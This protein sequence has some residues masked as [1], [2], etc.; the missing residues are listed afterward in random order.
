MS[1]L[2]AFAPHHPQALALLTPQDTTKPA[3]Y[4]PPASVNIVITAD[5]GSKV[6]YVDQSNFTCRAVL[7]TETPDEIAAAIGLIALTGTTKG[8]FWVGPWNINGPFTT[9][10][11][12][13]VKVLSDENGAP[14]DVQIDD[15][16]ADVA[17]AIVS[18]AAIA[19]TVIARVV[20]TNP[21]TQATAA[22]VS[23]WVGSVVVATADGNTIVSDPNFY[24]STISNGTSFIVKWYVPLNHTL[25]GITDGYVLLHP[26]TI[27]NVS[28]ITE[29]DWQ[30]SI[31]AYL[32]QQVVTAANGNTGYKNKATLPT[33]ILQ[34]VN[35]S[36]NNFFKIGDNHTGTA[37]F[38]VAMTVINPSATLPV[39]ATS[40]FAVGITVS[41]IIASSI[42]LAP[43][44]TWVFTVDVITGVI[45]GEPIERGLQS[46]T[47]SAGSTQATGT[48]VVSSG[49][50]CTTCA[51]AG[52]AFTI[53]SYTPRM[54]II[55]NNGA[56]SLDLFPPVGGTID[57]G[58]ANAA[59]AITNVANVART[60][61]SNDGLNWVTV[62]S[63]A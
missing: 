5:G 29:T 33:V 2:H 7:V 34:T 44:S 38:P 59:L 35:A 9:P 30:S 58:A 4:I 52:D 48:P 63:N 50:N 24:S 57:G 1:T 40:S 62:L 11:G 39:V 19:T 14:R 12:G 18:A 26:N 55:Q 49:V 27:M 17:T 46:G 42:T 47:A 56:A 3:F 16:F 28:K 6:H 32:P 31:V 41:G 15:D 51:T 20:A 43:L 53:Q 8:A 61:F 37:N 45:S 21:G 23:G 36:P 10:T 13:F 54:F 60:V 25:N 22:P